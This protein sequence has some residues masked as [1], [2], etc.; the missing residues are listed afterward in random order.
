MSIEKHLQDMVKNKEESAKKGISVGSVLESISPFLII[1]NLPLAI[2]A[3]ATGIALEAIKKNKNLKTT[4][5]PDEWLEKVAQSSTVSE[6]GLKFLRKRINDNNF[7]TVSEALTFLDIENE[8]EALLNKQ[9]EKDN[10]NIK[11]E[12]HKG[13]DTLKKRFETLNN[14]NVEHKG[15]FIKKVYK[16]ALEL[17]PK[18]LDMVMTLKNKRKK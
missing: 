7:I 11:V 2:T 17:S 9:N 8:H 13:L 14:N 6:K 10:S 12:D 18:A 3:G 16:E 15:S 1:I 5:M 4:K